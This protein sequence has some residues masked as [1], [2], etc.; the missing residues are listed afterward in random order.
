M[1]TQCTSC[2]DVRHLA[3]SDLIEVFLLLRQP[4]GPARR[5]S[6][7]VAHDV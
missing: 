4:D 3:V 7:N 5:S 6:V 1:Q 2:A